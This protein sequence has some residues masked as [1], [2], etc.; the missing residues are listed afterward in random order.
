ML[1]KVMLI[2]RLGRDPELKYTTAGEAMVNFS[3]ATNDYYKD[4]EGNRQEKT[5]WHNISA[6]G[7]LAETCNTYLRKGSLIY[8]EGQ[9]QTR[10]YQD[11]EGIERYTTSIV[12]RSMNMLDKKGDNLGESGSEHFPPKST[13]STSGSFENSFSGKESELDN[14]DMPF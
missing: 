9:I 10:K 13:S 7:R 11:K 5:E 4:K 3:I 6:F 12:M 1:N 8:A 14:N 2:G